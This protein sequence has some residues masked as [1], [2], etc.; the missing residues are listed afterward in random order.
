MKK[1]LILESNPRRDLALNQEIRDLEGVVKR[2]RNKDQFEV[3]IGLAVRREDLQELLL[4]YEPQIVHFCGHGAGEQGLVL[5]T[6]TGQEQLVPTDALSSLFELFADRV[7]CILLN[8]CYSEVQADAIVT[9]INYVVGMSQAIRDDAAIAFATGFYRALGYGRPIAQAYKFGC[10]AIQLSIDT[11]VVGGSVSRSTSEQQR[12]AEVV[13]AVERVMIPEYLKPILKIKPTLVSQAEP[14]A[15]ATETEIQVD[16]DKALEQEAALKQYRDRV[17]EYLSDRNLSN[18][19]KIRL[20]Q[21]RK[22]IGLSLEQAEQIYAEEWEPIQRSRDEYEE[23]LI[24]LIGDG[25]YPFDREINQELANLCQELGLTEAEVEAI[26]K[27]I[28]EAAESEYQDRQFRRSLHLQSLQFQSATINTNKGSAISYQSGQADYFVEDLG[29]VALEMIAISRGTFLMGS[30]EN[31]LERYEFESPQHRVT[32]QP[33][34]MGKVTVTQAQW[35]AIASLPK[36]NLDLDA[37]P[38]YFK[39]SD[40]PVEQVSW[41][42]AIEFCDRLSQKTGKTYRLPSEAEWEY[43]CRA[44]TTTPFH[45]GETIATDLANYRGSD[46]ELQGTT[47]PGFYGAGNRGSLRE[48]TIAVASFPSNA[49]GL[50]D[51]HG[52]VWEWC[53][54]LWHENYEGAPIDGSAWADGNINARLIRGGSWSYIPGLCRSAF[55]FPQFPRLPRQRCRVLG[56]RRALRTLIALCPSCALFFSTDRSKNFHNPT[57]P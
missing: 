40:R 37:D 55:R 57:P 27:P 25:C 22:K 53:S 17:R 49:F 39:G 54:D 35:K 9:H 18:F 50:Y 47:Y 44:G 12:R 14:I 21:L 32:V 38:S 30:P 34:Y 43:A 3:K 48:E 6:A 51:M 28:L 2:S 8:A 42:D 4:D 16:V 10:N 46:W 15:G 13:N 45:F 31:E 52:N 36:V 1:I 29:G 26:S 20:G 41:D 33:F 7:E 24:E 56:C 23:M 19:E 11:S 5:Q